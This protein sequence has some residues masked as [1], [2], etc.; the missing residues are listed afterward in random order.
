MMMN[1]SAG[2]LEDDD[3]RVEIRAGNDSNVMINGQSYTKIFRE[4]GWRPK[5]GNRYG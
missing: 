1:A 3:Y 2:F 4:N 5:D